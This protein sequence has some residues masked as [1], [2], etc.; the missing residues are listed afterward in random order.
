[1]KIL[2]LDF[3]GVMMIMRGISGKKFSEPCIES[4]KEILKDEGVS[5]VISSSW[6]MYGLDEMKTMFK[7]NGLDPDRVIDITGN[8]RGPRGYQIKCWLERNGNPAKFV[9][10]DD[11]SDMEPFINKLVK[12]SPLIGLTKN[13]AK[14][15][16][17]IL[18]S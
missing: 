2:F 7:D 5:V 10:L 17:K 13:D 9:I 8:E 1:M 18:N 14:M 15:A 6:R 12:I 16:K 4:L 11:N 3:D